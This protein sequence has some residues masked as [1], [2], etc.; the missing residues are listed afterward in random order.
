MTM[1]R[2]PGEPDEKGGRKRAGIAAWEFLG[3]WKLGLGLST[4][5]FLCL[6]LAGS[7]TAAP[8]TFAAIGDFGS[9]YISTRQV[10]WRINSWQPQFII[11][12]GDNNYPAGS[13]ATIDRNIGQFYHDY[14]GRYK[15]RYGMGAFTNRFFPSLGN[16][17]WLTTNA[18]PYL[19]Y[20]NLPGN[21]RYYTFTRGPVQLFCLDSDKNEPDGTS[22][23]SPQAQ[24]LQEQ[25]ANSTAVWRLVY[26]HHAPYS[27]GEVHGTHTGETSRMR[28]PFHE[29][30]VDAVLAGHDHVYERVHTNGLVYFVNGLGGDSKD[31]FH[32]V[33][34]AG[35][36]VRYNTDFG[37][38][39]IDAAENYILFRFFSRHGAQI[40]SYRMEP[41][42][43]PAAPAAR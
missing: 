9:D 39:R 42:R 21:E 18:Q 33:P 15:G 22:H 34:V 16:H 6:F 7:A 32:P 3:S 5:C 4:R 43:R 2:G 10:A 41:Q 1:D 20:F 37:A 19:H 31:K 35:S 8:I 14:I 23:D 25:L 13:A 24:W 26:F 40:D 30:G 36:A 28:W 17:D 12:L 11:T 29:W 27:S 38:L